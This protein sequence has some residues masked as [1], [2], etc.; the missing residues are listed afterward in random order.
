LPAAVCCRTETRNMTSRIPWWP[1]MLLQGN[2]ET[3]RSR[4]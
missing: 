2:R 4:L 1:S 3:V